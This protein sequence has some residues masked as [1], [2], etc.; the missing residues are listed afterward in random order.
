MVD[1][2]DIRRTSPLVA[3]FFACLG[4]FIGFSIGHRPRVGDFALG[5][6][7]LSLVLG[8]LYPLLCQFLDWFGSVRGVLRRENMGSEV[9]SSDLEASLSS[10]IGTGGVET[11]ISISIPSSS[12]P[13]VSAS[14]QSFHAL[15]EECSLREDT[16]IRFRYRFQFPEETRVYLPRKGKKSCVFAYGEVCFYETAFLCGLRFPVHLFI[17]ELLHYPNIAQDNLC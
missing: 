1:Y 12:L 2:S 17:M 7:S 13:S 8:D 4:V 5:D 9:R 14:P 6:S 15:K 16:F 11:D 10:S 3:F